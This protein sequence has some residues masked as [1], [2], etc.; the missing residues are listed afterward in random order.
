ML[1]FKKIFNVLCF[2][3]TDGEELT[4]VHLGA[5]AMGSGL[6][7]SFVVTP[8]ERIK[9]VMQAAIASA[10]SPQAAAAASAT[11]AVAGGLT[12]GG[13][14]YSNAWGC[15]RGL[16]AENGLQKGLYAGLGATLLREVPG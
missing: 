14:G 3:P 11:K 12:R 5:A 13:A 16:V 9:V 10:P 15:A 2:F 7:G 4:L 1:T 8:V 6:V